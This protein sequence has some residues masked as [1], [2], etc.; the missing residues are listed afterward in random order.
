M[1]KKLDIDTD[2]MGLYFIFDFRNPIVITHGDCDGLCA[3]ALLIKEYERNGVTASLF[4]TQPFSLHTILKEIHNNG[5]KGNIIIVDLALA[6]KVMKYNNKDVVE[7]LIPSGSVVIDHHPSSF[8]YKEDLKKLGIYYFMQENTSSSQLVSKLVEQTRLTEYIARLGGVGDWIIYDKR[9]GRDTSM[10]SA[11]MSLD[12][13]D[14]EFRI[15]IIKELINGKNL[16]EIS[17]VEKRAKEA[18][19]KLDEAKRNGSILYDGNIYVLVFYE[20]GYGRAAALASKLAIASKKVALVLSI[21]DGSKNSYLLT[22]RP[23]P[24]NKAN[25]NLSNVSIYSLLEEFDPNDNG[26][27]LANAASWTIR[28]NQLGEFVQFIETKD[29]EMI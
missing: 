7:C 9:L 27:G 5:I 20:E 22:G 13:K 8:K 17:E 15:S 26:G 18:F 10:L 21:P 29:K 25:P 3:A 28:T 12:P 24:Y 2:D 11:A 4:I 6:K 19:K 16:N 23:P 1:Y 14:D